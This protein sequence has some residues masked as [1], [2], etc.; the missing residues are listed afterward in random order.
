[1][2]TDVTEGWVREWRKNSLRTSKGGAGV[3]RLEPAPGVPLTSGD[4]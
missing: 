2:W 1:M 4:L 3:T